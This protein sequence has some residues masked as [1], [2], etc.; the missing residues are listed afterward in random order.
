[1]IASGV[2]SNSF[3]S[4]APF[5]PPYRPFSGTYESRGSLVST[6]TSLPSIRHFPSSTPQGVSDKR[7]LSVGAAA[8][9]APSPPIPLT[10]YTLNNIADNP[11]AV[12]KKRRVGRG[13]GSSKGKT[14]GRGHKGQ[15][16][17]SGGKISPFFE[18]GQTPMHKRIPKR[19]FNNKKHADPMI[20]IAVAKIQDYID[21][22]RLIPPTT[23]PIN[24][25]DL[26]ESGLTKMSKIKHGCKLLSGKKLPPGADPPVRSAINIEISRASASA[27]R[28]IEEA[29]GTVTTVHYNRLALKALLK[30]HRFDVIPRRAAPPPKLLPY[31]TSYEKRGYLSPEVQ[32][33][34]KLGIDRNKILR[35]KNNTETGKELG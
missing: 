27:I 28:A 30:P 26:V 20:P 5:P 2:L 4:T 8:V 31:Y 9:N 21:M 14:S 17:R 3:F 6:S 15:K 10:F 1:M 32:I 24:M 7:D 35:V 23:R 16:S 25:L 11:G 13:T 12:K 33:R 34:N 19:G 22:G 18:G 29:G